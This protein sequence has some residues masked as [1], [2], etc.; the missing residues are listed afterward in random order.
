VNAAYV[1]SS[2]LVA[3]AFD[4]PEAK[5]LSPRLRRFDRLFASNLLEAEL[6]SALLREGVASPPD[7]LLS[8]ITWVFPNRSLTPELCRIAQVGYLKG[9]DLWHL[10]HAL[11]LAPEANELV[12][13]TL[14]KQ[15]AAVA[16][17]LGFSL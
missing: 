8:W 7:D 6:R 3:I 5:R 16:K 13:L 2:C 17:R 1:D 9:A 12:F 4:E 15:Q 10:A 11:H 14:D